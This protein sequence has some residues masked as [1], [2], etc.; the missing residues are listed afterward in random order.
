MLGIARSRVIQQ[1]FG[2]IDVTLVPDMAVLDQILEAPLRRLEMRIERT[3]PDDYDLATFE[4]IEARLR[5][6]NAQREEVVLVPDSGEHLTPDD[7]TRELARVAAEN[8]HVS[9]RVDTPAGV[10]VRSTKG[11]PLS[12]QETY[13]AE[14]FGTSTVFDRL[15]R[16]F[17]RRVLRTRRRR[18]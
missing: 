18:Q 1:R 10:R 9:A 16:E 14:D 7:E 17:V 6:N 12:V 2:Q 15:S 3:N 5:A 13:D 4:R 8:G 11:S